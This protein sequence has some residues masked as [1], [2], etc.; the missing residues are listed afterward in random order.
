MKTAPLLA[1]LGSAM[2]SVYAWSAPEYIA[3]IDIPSF[4]GTQLDANLFV[5][6][7]PPPEGGYPTVIF[8]NSWGLEKHQYHFQAKELAENGYLVLSYSTRGFGFSGG[9]VDV[10]GANSIADVGVLIDWLEANYPVGKLG[11]A[12]ISYGGGISLLSA[13]RHPRVDAVAAMSGWADVVEALYPNET[14]NLV[15]G[16]LLVGTAFH[17]EA[18]LEHLWSDLRNG[19][20]IESVIQFAAER[21]AVSYVDE[22]NANG[23]AVLMSN[24]YADYLFKPNSMTDFYSM[25][26]GPKK[27]LLNPGTH[28]ITE[29]L[30]GNYGHI[31]TTTFRWFDRYLKGEDNGIDREPKVD[32]TVRISNKLEHFEDYPV[33]QESTTWYLRP[34]FTMFDNGSMKGSKYSGWNWTNEFHGGADTFAGTG[35]PLISDA[36]EGFG[37]PVYTPMLA[38]N[39]YFAIEYKSPVQWETLKIRGE[40]QLEMWVKPSKKEVQLNAHLYDV[41]PLG[42]GRLITHAPITL[43]SDQSGQMQKFDLEMFTTSYDVPPGHRVVLA[44]DTQGLIYQKPDNTNY[45][46]EVPY[47]SSK[48]SSLTVPHL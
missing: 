3:D 7:T 5:P 23:T 14:V 48:V 35:I 37:I 6:D 30:T 10:A 29:T 8:T 40:P 28:A 47:S 42:L 39:G 38:I 22:L 36:L 25:L 26:E 43:H 21:S 19:Q 34:R 9:L 11:M 17:K 4:D 13:A 1:L 2:M 31:W 45:T 24:N 33:T 18:E 15:W 44:I 32:M 20:N 27:L 46:I 12:G 41:G 16:S